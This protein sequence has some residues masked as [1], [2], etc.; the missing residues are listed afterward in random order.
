MKLTSGGLNIHSYFPAFETIFS[1]TVEVSVKEQGK[2]EW[3]ILP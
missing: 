2:E 1:A 3:R